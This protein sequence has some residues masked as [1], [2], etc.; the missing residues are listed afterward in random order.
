MKKLQK[1]FFSFTH[2][3]KQTNKN[4]PTSVFYLS[5]PLAR[6]VCASNAIVHT[7]FS[8]NFK[9][10]ISFCLRLGGCLGVWDCFSLLS[11]TVPLCAWKTSLNLPGDQGS[12]VD[13]ARYKPM[14]LNKSNTNH[15][16]VRLCCSQ[17]C[18]PKS[19]YLL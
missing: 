16:T 18:M 12:M 19:G 8:D 6:K 4:K 2:T 15:N 11:P 3:Q 17:N 14:R 5:E 1:Q 10:F 9:G 7:T 13:T